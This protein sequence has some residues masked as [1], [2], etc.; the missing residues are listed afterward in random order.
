MDEGEDDG[1][2]VEGNVDPSSINRMNDNNRQGGE[3]SALFS[4]M[5]TLQRQQVLFQNELSQFKCTSTDLLTRLHHS[6]QRLAQAPM[7]TP[8]VRIRN[9]TSTQQ[10]YNTQEEEEVENTAVRQLQRD[11]TL[12]NRATLCTRPRTLFVLWQ[13]YEFGIAGKK[14][15]K[16]F[17]PRERGRSKYAYSL[18]K[19]FWDLVVSMISHGYNH[20][21]AIDKIY[22]VDGN[23]LV[24]KV[25]RLIQ[26]DKISGGHDKLINFVTVTHV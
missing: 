23:I 10:R 17:T 14:A 4:Q 12:D 5:R 8:R 16:L 18:R 15:A 19:S 6:V 25:L 26:R 22:K 13:E 9:R 11:R 21:T 24:I 20:N 3:V 7:F 1:D 2:G